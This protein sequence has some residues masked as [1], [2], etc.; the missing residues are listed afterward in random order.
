[1]GDS[2]STRTSPSPSD[3]DVIV[4]RESSSG[5]CYTVRQIPG[6]V[7][8]SVAQWEDAIRLARSFARNH[9]VDL[10]YRENGAESLLEAYRRAAE[11][12]TR[13]L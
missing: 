12:R 9:A 11:S 5:V 1:M 3:G 2:P 4:T 6:I 7:Q 8:Y 13:I 10:W